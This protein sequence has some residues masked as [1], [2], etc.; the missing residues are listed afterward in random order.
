MEV[1]VLGDHA[2]ILMEMAASRADDDIEIVD[3]VEVFVGE[4]FVDERPEVLGWLQFRAVGWLV[5]EP[6]AVGNGEVLRAVPTG[7]VELKHDDAVASGAGGACEGFEQLGEEGFVDAVR[8]EPDGLAAGRGNESGDIEPFVAM[9]A[10]RDRPLADGRPDPTVDRLQPEAVLVRRPDLDRLVGMFRFFFGQ[11]VGEL[12]LKAA[13]ACGPAAFGFF[14]RGDWIDQPIALSASQPRCG[15]SFSSPSS[16]AMKSATLRLD[17]TPPS[18]GGSRS[19]IL[20]F[21]V[22]LA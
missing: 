17:H 8:Q 6:D 19:R 7:V 22:D 18:G 1:G 2:A 4:R 15:A 9:M 13:S 16:A 11:R 14:G 3:C 12:F 20:S 10:E 5:D 21:P